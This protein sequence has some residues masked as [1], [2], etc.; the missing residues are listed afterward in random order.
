M[1]MD[2]TTPRLVNPGAIKKQDE[3]VRESKPVH[4]TPA[5]VY[6]SRPAVLQFPP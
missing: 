5:S 6:A 2:S 1:I 4:N 3:Q